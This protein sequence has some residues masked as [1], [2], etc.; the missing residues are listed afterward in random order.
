[1]FALTAVLVVNRSTAFQMLKIVVL[2]ST[3]LQETTS[4]LHSKVSISFHS[5]RE[6]WRRECRRGLILHLYFLLWSMER[7]PLESLLFH[8]QKP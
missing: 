7:A 2:L 4:A 5:E 1:M 3:K 8:M 6:C